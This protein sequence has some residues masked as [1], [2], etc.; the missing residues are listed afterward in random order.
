MTEE[1]LRVVGLSKRFGGSV[2]LDE[3]DFTLN[4]G[5]VHALLGQNGSG[6]STFV[7]CLTNV[8]VPDA[9]TLEIYGEQAAFPLT[10]PFGQGIAVVHQDIGLVD[11][12]TVLENLSIAA[13][14]GTTLLRSI[15]FRKER[16]TYRR[17]MGEWRIDL[18]LDKP[19]G[20]L[21]AAERSL[22][23]I[24]RA[25]RLLE[26]SSQGQQVL[27]LDEPTAA[28]SH[29]EAQHLLALMRT[30]ADRGSAVLF[31]SHR[32]AE[33]EQ[34]C[35]VVTVLRAGRNVG[36]VDVPSSSRRD[37][38]SMMLGRPIAE[39]FPNVA[40]SGGRRPVLKVRSLRNGRL[41][42]VS[43]DLHEGEILGVTGLAGMG[44][45][46]IP[47]ALSGAERLEEG[48]VEL[49][50]VAL[51]LHSPSD[52]LGRGIAM[53]PSNRL[54]D[55]IWAGGTAEDNITLPVLGR[56]YRHG[57]LLGR[58][59]RRLAKTLM[60]DVNVTPLT[61]GLKMDAFSGGNQQKIVFAKWLQLDPSVLLLDEPTQGVDPAS[62]RGLL[63]EVAERAS[64]GVAV[65]VCS[66]DF[67]QLAEICHRVLVFNHGSIVAQLS[68]ENLTE[69]A[70]IE[71]SELSAS[72]QV[73]V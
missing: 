50:G 8:V 17:L 44:Q 7:K 10:D 12:M 29:S 62:A 16:A 25:A 71:A 57:R 34:V 14:F 28:L 72:G 66:G 68:G 13:H 53:I 55:G 59:L 30:V 15:D 26:V 3:V 61:P 38:V 6:K 39:F 54:R 73:A 18:P 40:G 46:S 21:S 5:E 2:A 56:Y 60:A 22:T 1:A 63:N 47:K 31:I 11:S 19:V 33:V 67:E 65:L 36:T 42:G 43:F 32:L 49:E 52:A 4:T 64:R 41:N 48:E 45:E 27:I 23:G 9:G 69:D 24:V 70:L 35:D 37:W 51:A 20:L 58:D